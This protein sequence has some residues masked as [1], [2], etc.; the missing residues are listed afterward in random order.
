MIENILVITDQDQ[1][2]LAALEKAR[3]VAA[4]FNANIVVIAFV[5]PESQESTSAAIDKH[6]K[7]LAEQAQNYMKVLGD[8]SKHNLSTDLYTAA[9]V[10]A[11]EDIGKT[12]ELDDRFIK[13]EGAAR[14]GG[15]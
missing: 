6:K 12:F 7:Q 11:V 5:A 9:F 3:E 4:P 2:K 1:N 14:G 13:S 15:K 10:V 8:N